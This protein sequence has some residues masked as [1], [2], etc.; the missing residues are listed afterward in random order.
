VTAAVDTLTETMRERP[1]TICPTCGDVIEP[2]ELDVVEAVE[3]VAVPGFDAPS[4]TAE[5]MG[6]VFHPSCFPE[7]HPPTGVAEAGRQRWFEP[8]RPSSSLDS[9]IAWSA[10]LATR[11][12]YRA[13][14]R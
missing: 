11:R 1:R 10:G 9:A 7:G 8:L 5:G 13:A 3:I 2:D 4:D 12:T 14:R 6:V